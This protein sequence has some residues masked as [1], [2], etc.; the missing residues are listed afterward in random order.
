MDKNLI[1]SEI[2][3]FLNGVSLFEKAKDSLCKGV[4]SLINM[5]AKLD[6]S[7][8]EINEYV[9]FD[10]IDGEMLYQYQ[11]KSVELDEDGIIIIN[12][13]GLFDSEEK[14][15]ELYYLSIEEI[16]C[17][18]SILFDQYQTKIGSKLTYNDMIEVFKKNNS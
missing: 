14:S 15:F 16:Q 17:L 7:L 2:A 18:G 1:Q 10:Y 13:D 12:C 8:L 5:L 4:E 3:S 9:T 6:E 11:V